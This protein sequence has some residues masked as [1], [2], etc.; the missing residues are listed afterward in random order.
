MTKFDNLF[1]SVLTNFERMILEKKSD[2]VTGIEEGIYKDNAENKETLAHLQEMEKQAKH[3]REYKPEVLIYVRGGTVQTVHASETMTLTIY[4]QDN[5]D[6]SDDIEA[7]IFE[8]EYGTPEQWEE[9]IK[10]K[11]KHNEITE[12]N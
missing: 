5:L 8:Q 3:L 2:I 4:D 12:L 1:E 11:E 7:E 6:E 9:V 10:V